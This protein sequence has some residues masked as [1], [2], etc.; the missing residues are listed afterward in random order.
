[1]FQARPLRRAFFMPVEDDGTT[2]EECKQNVL[3]TLQAVYGGSPS[4]RNDLGISTNLSFLIAPIQE[5]K[6][7]SDAFEHS[8]TP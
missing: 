7:C 2:R 1:M 4:C 5:F 8:A 3:A 6:F